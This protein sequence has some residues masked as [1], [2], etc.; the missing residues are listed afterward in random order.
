[1]EHVEGKPL[2]DK[3]GRMRYRPEIICQTLSSFTSVILYN[4][5][6]Y[7]FDLFCVKVIK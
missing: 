4:F 2:R 3:E 1:M 6:Q 5:P 7:S